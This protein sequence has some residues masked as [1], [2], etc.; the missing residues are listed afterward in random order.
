MLQ[1]LRPRV[2]G[3]IYEFEPTSEAW[4]SGR[5]SLSGSKQP[6]ILLRREQ[7][8]QD[9]FIDRIETAQHALQGLH[10]EPHRD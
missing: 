6:A 1:S 7:S 4:L 2:D 8:G 5:F 9:E 3:L 10:D